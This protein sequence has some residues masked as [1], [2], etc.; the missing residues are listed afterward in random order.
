MVEFSPP[1]TNLW[2]ILKMLCVHSNVHI[3]S[4]ELR[5]FSQQGASLDAVE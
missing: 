2:S 1:Y 4:L 5:L 3:C